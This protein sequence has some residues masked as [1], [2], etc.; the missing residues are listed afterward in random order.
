MTRVTRQRIDFVAQ[1]AL[2]SPRCG[3]LLPS[4]APTVAFENHG[5]ATKWPCAAEDLLDLI[6]VEVG[7]CRAILYGTLP[8]AFRLT[9]TFPILAFVK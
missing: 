8:R 4:G 2:V 9:T 5:F 3:R 1:L 6:L 7:R